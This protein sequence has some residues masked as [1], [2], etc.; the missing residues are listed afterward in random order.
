M[1]LYLIQFSVAERYENINNTDKHNL[2]KPFPR[3]SSYLI[4]F[5]RTTENGIIVLLS[6]DIA[7]RF[8]SLFLSLFLFVFFFINLFLSVMVFYVLFCESSNIRPFLSLHTFLRLL[9]LPPL[10]PKLSHFSFFSCHVSKP[11]IS[12]CLTLSLLSICLCLDLCG[13]GNE[14]YTDISAP[15]ISTYHR[16]F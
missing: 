13:R 8:V 15:F 7:F 10:R 3:N 5:Q 12:A 11:Y 16:L 1:L 9:V 2:F 14:R 6:C 4:G